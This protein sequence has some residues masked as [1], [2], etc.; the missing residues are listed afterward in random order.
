MMAPLAMQTKVVK[1][2][3]FA[4]L[5][6]TRIAPPARLLMEALRATWAATVSK[7]NVWYSFPSPLWSLTTIC[8]FSAGCYGGCNGSCDDVCVGSCD[9]C[10][11]GYGFYC[12]CDSFC[13]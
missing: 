5:L 6:A 8:P 13:T 11:N 1:V 2:A 12:S 7:M 10:W 3:T 4:F 9:G